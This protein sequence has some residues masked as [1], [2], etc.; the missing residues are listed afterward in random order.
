MSR[1]KKKCRAIMF[2]GSGIDARDV[3]MRPSKSIRCIEF[4]LI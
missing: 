3:A 2:V 4:E 1:A